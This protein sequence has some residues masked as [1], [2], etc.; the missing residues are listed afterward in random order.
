[1]EKAGFIL[2][3]ERRI[4]KYGSKPN[5]YHFDGLIK[6]LTPYAEEKIEMIQ[7]KKA[8]DENRKK[9]RKPYL[10]LITPKEEGEEKE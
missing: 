4:S 1:M 7:R 5:R 6:T 2:R 8:E 10:R 9:S 3:E